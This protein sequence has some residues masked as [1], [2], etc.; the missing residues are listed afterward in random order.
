[1]RTKGEGELFVSSSF[2]SASRCFG[3]VEKLTTLDR[4]PGCGKWW[5]LRVF[6]LQKVSGIVE[7]GKTHREIDLLVSFMTCLLTAAS[8]LDPR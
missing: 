4:V 1:V 6:P 5:H 2:V 8:F 7:G 3:L